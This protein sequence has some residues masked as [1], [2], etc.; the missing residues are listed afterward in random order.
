MTTDVGMDSLTL[1]T[2]WLILSVW[3][4][5]LACGAAVMVLW[6]LGT[7]GWHWWVPI[8][9]VAAVGGLGGGAAVTLSARASWASYAAVLAGLDRDQRRQL[10]RVWRRGPVPADTDVLTAA[11]RYHA[12]S[13][14][15]RLRTQ[16]R[17][18]RGALLG[19]I[20]AVAVACLQLYADQSGALPL[21]VGCAVS[22]VFGLALIH[23]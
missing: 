18:R 21:L 1:R 9:G 6:P 17:R 4:F 14:Q 8:V 5:L 10:A 15:Y 19:G 12:L 16:K 20:A 22:A 3:L 23:R 11:L 7:R 13:K 2:R